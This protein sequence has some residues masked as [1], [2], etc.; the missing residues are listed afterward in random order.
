MDDS[1]YNITPIQTNL[2]TTTT[3]DT[4]QAVAMGIGILIAAA[5]ITLL[6]YAIVAIFLGKLFKKAGIPAWQAWVPILNSWKM[7]ELGGKPG[8]WAV[9]AVVPVLN[10]VSAIFGIIA[11]HNI[12]LKLRYDAG[13]TVLAVLV[14][15]VWF[16]IV[17]TSS[18]TWDDSLGAPRLDQPIT[19]TEPTDTAPAAPELAPSDASSLDSTDSA[20]STPAEPQPPIMPDESSQTPESTDEQPPESQG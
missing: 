10:I 14:P 5:I 9:L 1:L 2:S 6:M 8:F 16:I 15:L 7:F 13:M 18:H 20:D 4:A 12:N 11:M 19:P 3:I 17:G